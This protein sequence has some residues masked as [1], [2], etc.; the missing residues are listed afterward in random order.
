MNKIT[1]YGKD[2]TPI[3][4]AKVKGHELTDEIN[5]CDGLTYLKLLE[6]FVRDPKKGQSKEQQGNPLYFYADNTMFGRWVGV[7]RHKSF[8]EEKTKTTFDI[9]LEISCRFDSDK[10]ASFLASMLL[11]LNPEEL[12]SKKLDEV[13]ITFHQV[14]D[15]FLLFMFKNQLAGAAK[16]GIF[17]KYQR[18][19]NNDSRPHGTLDIAR[20][21][22]ENMGLKSG[23]AAY[24]YRELSV[25]N[26]MNR[27]IL[28]AYKRLCEK[29]PMLCQKRIDSE[30]SVYSTLKML[31][32][33]LGCF[34]TNVRNIVKENLRP[35]T[36]LYFSEYEDL[37]KTCLKILRDE[38]VSIF[39]ADCSEETESL[40]VDVTR[41]WE[42]F[43]ESHLETQLKGFGLSLTTQGGSKDGKPIF[44]GRTR[45][46][47]YSKPD[48]VFW[49]GERQA[50][51]I[52]DA[53]FKPH[54]NAFFCESTSE[55]GRTNTA[56]NDDINKCI[57]DMVVFQASRT[58][59]IF[60]FREGEEDSENDSYKKYH[61]GVQDDSA[62]IFDM[63][64]VRIPP[65]G[66]MS[67]EDWY[68]KILEPAVDQVLRVYLS[69]L[70]GK[71][72]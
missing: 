14:M 62:P 29:F 27:L 19:E 52:L 59:V 55:E 51:A 68:H 40:C 23:S 37:R 39:D 5:G 21:I 54:W 13:N 46:N 43:L 47:R 60:P 8:Q 53:K 42:Q 67:F 65:E 18:F 36:H 63:V 22:R 20:H 41:L 34:K 28:A 48:F 71:N 3:T 30:E 9:T 4:K 25:N 32:T 56:I 2:F 45:N 24:H 61:I 66:K 10:T 15:I 64:R 50:C 1:F 11:C 38:N 16:K 17:R 6:Q 12:K 31:Q 69:D 57:R 58:G 44:A 33:E 72:C 49:D 35:I 70:S 7:F 26:P